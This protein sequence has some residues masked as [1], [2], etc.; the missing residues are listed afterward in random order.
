MA[1][2]IY[3]NDESAVLGT[4]QTSKHLQRCSDSVPGTKQGSRL[5]EHPSARFSLLHHDNH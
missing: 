4:P 3:A 2:K 1:P 5:T